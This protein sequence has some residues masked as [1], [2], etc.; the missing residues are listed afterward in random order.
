MP[1]TM[2]GEG[3]GRAPVGSSPLLGSTAIAVTAAPCATP[4]RAADLDAGGF[5]GGRGKHVVTEEEQ[6]HDPALW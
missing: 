3:T 6:G 4:S 5:G 1:V 2:P